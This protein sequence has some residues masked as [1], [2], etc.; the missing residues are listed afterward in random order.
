MEP[1]PPSF[2]GLPDIILSAVYGFLPGKD[3]ISLSLTCK[4]LARV[5]RDCHVFASEPRVVKSA[6]SAVTALTH[7]TNNITITSSDALQAF[8]YAYGTLTPRWPI[9]TVR[10][11][12]VA[13]TVTEDILGVPELKFLAT[14]TICLELEISGSAADRASAHSI[15]Q[16]PL[17]RLHISSCGTFGWLSQ[18]LTGLTKL[19]A[20]QIEESNLFTVPAQLAL[21][22]NLQELSLFYVGVETI[23]PQVLASLTQ[24]TKFEV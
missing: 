22:T 19:E 3:R 21:L 2:A 9:K 15:S 11:R 13:C 8:A 6:L 10:L 4:H 5:A 18:A 23:P 20:L 16:L 14:P 17:R 1:E 12:N 7:R 24:L